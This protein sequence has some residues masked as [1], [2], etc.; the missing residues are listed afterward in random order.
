M[1]GTNAN[2]VRPLLGLRGLVSHDNLPSFWPD[3]RLLI[4]S[5]LSVPHCPSCASE[6]SQ[7]S[8]LSCSWN[9]VSFFSYVLPVDGVAQRRFFN[10]PSRHGSMA[11]PFFRVSPFLPHPFRHSETVQMYWNEVR[12]LV[13]PG[14][15]RDS[16]SPGS[17]TPVLS[18]E[19][20]D[21]CHVGQTRGQAS[22][23]HWVT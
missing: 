5:L 23:C 10:S 19:A 20:V 1:M 17:V 6:V 7:I 8:S 18:A 13:D 11:E 16:T 14:G 21:F 9:C 15:A 4:H 22:S 12:Q 3:R 2:I